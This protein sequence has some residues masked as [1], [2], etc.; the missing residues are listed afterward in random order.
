VR[1]G[2]WL[3]VGL[4]YLGLITGGWFAGDL[5][6]GMALLEVLP[7]TE[8]R[9]HATIMTA[10]LVF[11]LATA[12]PFVPGAEIGFALIMVFGARIVLLV[13]VAMV[14]ALTLGYLIGRLVPVA[15]LAA[16]FGY[17]GLRKARDLAVQSQ[18]LNADARLALLLAEAPTR[19]IPMLLR[20]R[21]LA[22]VVLFN[23]PGN[24]VIGGGGGIAFAAGISRLFSFPRYL[25]A[26]LVAVAPVPL[27]VALVDRIG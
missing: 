4:V 12:V 22:L 9:V 26:V 17:L 23:L 13:Y 20:H 19:V 15:T 14:A 2:R 11:V 16:V 1:R 7:Q 8:N 5:L 21:Y 25:L 6:D 3:A 27:Y 24:S 10:T 18:G